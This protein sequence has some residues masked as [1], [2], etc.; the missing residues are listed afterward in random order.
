[1]NW[2][3]LEMIWKRQ[4]LPRGADADLAT[5]RSTFEKKSRQQAKTLLVRDSAE[6]L[7]G[8]VVMMFIAVVWWHQGRA[9]WP[10]G[11]ALLLI[12]GVTLFFARERWRAR[13]R[14]LPAEAPLLMR[15]DA[16]IAELKR[17]RHLLWNVVWWYLAPIGAAIGLM[18]YS[19]GRG[20]QSWEVT[21]QW[22]F[23]GFYWLFVV[24]LLFWIW[25]V[26]RRTVRHRVV[27]RLVE[28]QKLRADLMATGQS[29]V[30]AGGELQEEGL[31][32][33]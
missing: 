16:D 26:N 28:L 20:R 1:M 21:G 27:P 33:K 25:R 24:A 23:L 6:A 8:A 3:D 18:S 13:R 11:I 14:H 10:A 29:R 5:L 32:P 17:Q 15:L 7:A 12:L 19:L 22:W 31:R 9:G 4:Q 30:E 2:S